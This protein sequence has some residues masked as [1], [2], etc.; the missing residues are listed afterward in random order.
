VSIA[1]FAGF[2]DDP[3]FEKLAERYPVPPDDKT[4]VGKAM[5]AG[6]PLQMVPVIDNPEAPPRTQEL[7][8][9]FDF[10]ALISAPLLLQDRVIG[11]INTAHRDPIQFGESQIELIVAMRRKRTFASHPDAGR[12][13]SDKNNRLCC[14]H[15]CLRYCTHATATNSSRTPASI[16]RRLATA[17]QFSGFKLDTSSG[18]LYSRSQDL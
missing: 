7:A 6:R 5:L 13:A 15:R 11:A 17:F 16:R 14:R 18:L 8:R 3:G 10:N 12:R 9:E 2:T 1:P 4:L